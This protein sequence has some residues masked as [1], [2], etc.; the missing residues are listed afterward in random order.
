MMLGLTVNLWDTS[1]KAAG[2]RLQG[3]E[4]FLYA[5]A[6]SPD[7]RTLATAGRDGLLKLWHLA[8]DRELGTMLKL[9]EDIQF[10]RL[11]FSPD[12]TWLGASDNHG[13]LHLFHAPPLSTFDPP[14]GQ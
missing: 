14:D 1:L 5:V 4:D 2:P 3:H 11:A 6:Y 7:G 10:A 13:R 12:G 9:P 8:S